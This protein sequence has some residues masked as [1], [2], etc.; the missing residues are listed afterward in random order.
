MNQEIVLKVSNLQKRI[1]N[2]MIIRDVSFELAR[3]EIVGL[4]GPNGS[5]KTTIL[6]MLVGLLRPS[7]GTVHTLGHDT[8]RDFEEAIQYVGA[9]IENPEMYDY[10]S[11]YDNLLHTLHMNRAQDSFTVNE[12]I[13]LLQLDS[14]VHD[15]VRTYSLGMKQRLGL[16]QSLM[17]RPRVLFLDEPT[18]GLDPEGMKDLRVLLKRLAVEQGVSII[19]SSHIL[20]EVELIC[21][22][23]MVLHDG[24]IVN[25][26]SLKEKDDNEDQY[27]FYTYT[28]LE[29]EK[30]RDLFERESPSYTT[31]EFTGKGFTV[32]MREKEVAELT[33]W[34]VNQGISV[35][36]IKRNEHTLEDR[37]LKTL[38]GQV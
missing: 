6:K 1:G 16:A 34:L 3:G 35:V 9:I 18:N 19:I 21:D 31:T 13:E 14:Y 4:L 22:R 7:N 27:S 20:A 12:V 24:R 2:S 10:L 28:V 17:H 29:V 30:V 38:K 25:E 11:G 26:A 23:V 37:F 5:G 15:K 8:Q 33:K 32:E 36:G